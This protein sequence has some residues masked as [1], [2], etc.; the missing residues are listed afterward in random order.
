MLRLDVAAAYLVPRQEL[1]DPDR[2]KISQHE[3]TEVLDVGVV[4]EC[5][6]VDVCVQ[7]EVFDL[8]VARQLDTVLTGGEA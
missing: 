6:A 5:M 2:A 4:E 1:Y 8:V 3:T 7:F